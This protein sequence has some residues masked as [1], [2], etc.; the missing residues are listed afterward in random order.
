M[1]KTPKKIRGSTRDI[2]NPLESII[3]NVYSF[4]Q[5]A[6]QND[7]YKSLFDLAKQ[8]D[9][10]GK[11]FDK[12]PVDMQG[13]KINAED[14]ENILGD[15]AE[16]I[17][18]EQLATTI[19]RPAVKQKGN[20]ISVM[21]NGKPTYYEIMDKDLF[22]I[23]APQITNKKDTF[24]KT[25][26][27][28]GAN[29]LRAGATL[30]TEFPL[31]NPIRDTIAAGV[32][33]KNDFIPFVD[34]AKGIFEIIGRSDLYYKWLE[35]GASGSSFTNAQR[36]TLQNTLKG[37]TP[38]ADKTNSQKAKETAAKIIKHPL[39]TALDVLSNISNLTEEG[40][41]VGEFRKAL[42][43]KKS[44]KQA[45]FESRDLMDF[46]KGGAQTKELN[47]TIAF[48]NARVIGVDKLVETFKERPMEAT[49][50]ALT[51][52]TLPTLIIEA[53]TG[54]DE[55]NKDIP[56]WE[57]DTFWAFY[58]GDTPV[59]IPKPQGLGEIFATIP[60]RAI[61]FIKEND[62]DAF[63]GLAA[64]L[65]NAY[66]PIDSFSSAIP[67]AAQPV[68]ENLTNYSFFKQQPIVNQTLEGRSPRYQY[69]QNTSEVAKTVGNLVN[70]S[71][72]KI[73]NLIS[74]L[75]GNLGKDVT[76]L[77]GVPISLLKGDGLSSKEGN[78]TLRDIPVLK[79]FIAN[80]TYDKETDNFYNELEQ[81]RTKK[82]DVKAGVAMS[83]TD[84]NRLAE[85]EKK[86]REIQ[87]AKKK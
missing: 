82:S 84:E 38:E 27:V 68:I 29:T 12:V 79:G 66:S 78:A 37:I 45:A 3:K 21:N 60:Q 50:K 35:S 86:Y 58:V 54:D 6:E 28:K 85:L 10:T 55:R 87:K 22:E 69:D 30:N 53:L 23:L 11:W 76:N 5:I 52:I 47:R 71:P 17:D 65:L 74:G 77:M 39:R 25:W 1:S 26:L 62:K 24:F 20:V 56:Q 49:I 72:K 36:K 59:K 48:L 83:K 51:Y 8:Y 31:R 2:I 64:R 33:S 73:D 81:L 13:I 75:S 61:R 41:K 63:D 19:F 70:Y 34:T 14:I 7:A 42:Q 15:N 57:R 44:V 67:T 43:N 4:N 32:H 9:G 40:T 18:A 46:S 80:D 16:G